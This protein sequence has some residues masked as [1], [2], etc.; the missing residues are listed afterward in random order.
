M[1][2]TIFCKVR[3]GNNRNVRGVQNAHDVLITLISVL[4]SCDVQYQI[5]HAYEGFHYCVVRG[6]KKWP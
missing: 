4:S 3:T 2:L 6:V 5:S 1:L